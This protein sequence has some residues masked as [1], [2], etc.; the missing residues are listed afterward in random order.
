MFGA[1][2]C[3]APRAVPQD[4]GS[5]LHCQ[6][7][8]VGVVEGVREEEWKR[9]KCFCHGRCHGRCLSCVPGLL[10]SS[11]FCLTPLFAEQG[12]SWRCGAQEDG[13]CARSDGCQEGRPDGA[14]QA[15]GERQHQLHRALR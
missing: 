14:Q 9:L 2:C 4:A 5:L 7:M 3:V 1:A 15:C 8:C 6:G 12:S 10:L 11:S 13:D